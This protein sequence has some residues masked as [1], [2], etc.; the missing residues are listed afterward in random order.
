MP[1]DH[2]TALNGNRRGLS[3]KQPSFIHPSS[4]VLESC[5]LKSGLRDR[6]RGE[7]TR[8]VKKSEVFS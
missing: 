7:T 4:S 2:L 6:V 3:Q 8:V 1:L 5:C